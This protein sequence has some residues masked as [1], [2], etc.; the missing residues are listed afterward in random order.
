MSLIIAPA[1]LV[2][3]G[4]GGGAKK[5]HHMLRLLLSRLRAEML[6]HLHTSSDPSILGRTETAL[7]GVDIPS[8]LFLIDFFFGGFGRRGGGRRESKLVGVFL[9]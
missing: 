1:F 3:G 6:R 7:I 5:K 2:K 4:K 9:F 8:R